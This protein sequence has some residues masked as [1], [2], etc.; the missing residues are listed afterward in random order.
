MTI[1]AIDHVTTGVNL[2][3]S[4]YKD[5]PNITALLT[6]YLNSLQEVETAILQVYNDVLSL[7]T[8]VG[9][10]LDICGSILDEP[11]AGSGDII[12]R[13]RLKTK[14]Q[15]IGSRGTVEDLIGI[16]RF[17][18]DLYITGVVP[19]RSDV[20]VVSSETWDAVSSAYR[21]THGR[22]SEMHIIP[23]AIN[24]YNDPKPMAP[25]RCH[26]MLL[27]AKGAGEA[28]Q[29][30]YAQ[31]NFGTNPFDVGQRMTHNATGSNTQGFGTMYVTGSAG[32]PAFGG[33]LAHRRKDTSVFV[34]MTLENILPP[35]LDGIDPWTVVAGTWYGL[36]ESF[37]YSLFR[38]NVLVEGYIDVSFTV[39]NSYVSSEV[40]EG[41]T[42]KISEEA[43]RQDGNVSVFSNDLAV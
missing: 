34:K 42:L 41:T 12:Y 39:I 15:V 30:I 26:D 5:Q 22:A 9:A 18:N 36:P 13:R 3:I 14:V 8:S 1:S 25:K 17:F 31:S 2:L 24:E 38:D 7:D 6:A 33:T 19:D 43:K 29:S 21:P 32:L 37:G 11:R 27:L 35:V 16:A 20:S 10:Q 40:D 23:N 4:Q 28:F